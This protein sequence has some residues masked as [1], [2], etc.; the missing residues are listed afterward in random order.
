MSP[1]L[2]PTVYGIGWFEGTRYGGYRP[3]VFFGTAIEL[4]LWMICMKVLA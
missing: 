4:G 1:R 2:L 3:R